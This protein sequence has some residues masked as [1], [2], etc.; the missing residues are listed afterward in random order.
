MYLVKQRKL[1]CD[2]KGVSQL[3]LMKK[4]V[5]HKLNPKKNLNVSSFLLRRSIKIPFKATCSDYFVLLCTMI[6]EVVKV[7]DKIGTNV[8]RVFFQLSHKYPF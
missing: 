3:K 1:K 2:D 5:K 7:T 4:Q 6:V 8:K